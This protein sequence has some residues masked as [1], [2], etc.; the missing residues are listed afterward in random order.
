MEKEVIYTCL[1]CQAQY[2]ESEIQGKESCPRCGAPKSQ[3]S[4]VGER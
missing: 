1:I 3:L 2:R 4:P